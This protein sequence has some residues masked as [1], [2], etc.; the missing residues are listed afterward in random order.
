MNYTV[1]KLAKLAGVSVRT[2]HYYDE[3]GLLPP[4]FV[5]KNGYRYYEEKELLLLQQILFFRELDFSLEKIKRILKSPDFQIEEALRNQRLL[6]KSRQKRNDKLINT[7]ELTLKRMKNKQKI[8]EEELY[9]AFQDDD[10]KQ[11]QEEVQERWGNTEA[12]KQSK[13]RVSKMTKVKMEK[14]KKEQEDISKAIAENMEKGIESDTIQSLIKRHHK[15]VSTFYDCPLEMYRN[16]GKMYIDDIR[17]AKN[18]EKVKKGLAI[19]MRDAIAY[20]CDKNS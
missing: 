5:V 20:Y 18:Y 19:F 7:I 10:V 13:E 1:N 11:Y 2:L 8:N 4:A 9:D 3:F 16:L 14:I 17:F 15:W 12:Y 6:L